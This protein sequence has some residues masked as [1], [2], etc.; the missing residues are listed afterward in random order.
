MLISTGASFMD[1]NTILTETK[2][3]LDILLK[4]GPHSVDELWKTWLD[5]MA[6]QKQQLFEGNQAVPG[7]NMILWFH[8]NFLSI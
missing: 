5:S 2:C 8:I 7:A 1:F 3:Q 6:Q 4:K